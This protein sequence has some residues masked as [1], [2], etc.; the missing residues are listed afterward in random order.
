MTRENKYRVW[1]KTAGRFLVPS[2]K[3]G[4]YL[5]PDGELRVSSGWNSYKEPTYDDETDQDRYEVTFF[6]G[7]KDEEDEIE[8]CEGDIVSM[9]QFL[10]E[11][12]EV[13][14]QI[15]GIIG[16]DEYGLTLTQIRNEFVEEYCG[17]DAGEGEL[18]IN[19]F[20]GLHECSW[21]VLGNRFEHPELLS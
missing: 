7:L 8:I 18:P 1:D 13:E 5:L 2:R 17:Y 16:W 10:F 12:T 20:Y 19:S 15:S 4:F 3:S 9:H 14:K 6:T 11:G 21:K